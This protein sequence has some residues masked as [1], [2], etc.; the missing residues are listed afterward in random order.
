MNALGLDK[1]RNVELNPPV[2]RFQW[3]RPGDMIH[4]DTLPKASP[5]E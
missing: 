1:L 3:E 5:Q 4:V 2:R